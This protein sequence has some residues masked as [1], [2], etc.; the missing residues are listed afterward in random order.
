MTNLNRTPGAFFFYLLV[1]FLTTLTMSMF[2]R[3]V[4]SLSRSLVEAVTPSAVV[5]LG[6]VLYTGYAIPINY[7]HGWARWINYIDPVAYGFEALMI[8]EFSGRNFECTNIVPAGPSY[9]NLANNEYSCTSVGSRAGA[10]TVSGDDYIN[11]AYGYYHSHKWRYVIYTCDIRFASSLTHPDVNS[12][13]GI[14][15]A[16]MLFLM[17]VYLIAAE[18]VSEKKSKGEVLLWPR[19]ALKKQAKAAK[20]SDVEKGRMSGSAPVT[21]RVSRAP[22]MS[23]TF[24]QTSVFHWQNLCY[25]VPIKKER[26]LILNNVDGWVKPGTLTALMGVSGAGK[27]TL[28]GA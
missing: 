4:A 12:N 27:T 19:W 21:S 9:T 17:T 18:L 7:M 8:N 23:K 5:I 28:L 20:T 14:I 1:S 24:K 22:E 2:F 11:L 15:I 25:T 3:S 26:R 6:L 16:F 10:L 13:V